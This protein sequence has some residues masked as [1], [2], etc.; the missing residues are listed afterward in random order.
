MKKKKM[1]RCQ[2]AIVLCLMAVVLLSGSVAAADAEPNQ[3]LLAILA[4][5][6]TDTGD[7]VYVSARPTINSAGETVYANYVLELPYGSAAT[8]V[9][10]P[11][12]EKIGGKIL[13]VLPA[14]VPSY[15]Y[16][17]YPSE[18]GLYHLPVADLLLTKLWNIPYLKILGNFVYIAYTLPVSDFAIT[19]ARGYAAQKQWINIGGVFDMEN[20]HFGN[21]TPITVYLSA[22]ENGDVADAIGETL[23]TTKAELLAAA[24]AEEDG[25]IEVTRYTKGV[26]L[27]AENLE[28]GAYYVNMKIGE[29]EDAVYTSQPYTVYATAK[30]YAKASMDQLIGYYITAPEITGDLIESFTLPTPIVAQLNKLRNA[31]YDFYSGV[32]YQG[33]SPFYGVFK[34]SATFSVYME[35]YYTG[36]A[37]YQDTG[38]DWE[39]WIFT[40]LG[41]EY[42]YE[43]SNGQSQFLDFSG[44]GEVL[45][46][47]SFLSSVADISTWLASDDDMT[48]L[49]VYA[50]SLTTFGV[51]SDYDLTQYFISSSSPYNKEA[52]RRVA[53]IMSMGADPRNPFPGESCNANHVAALLY[54]YYDQNTVT[55]DENG[56]ADYSEA[57]L[58]LTEDGK[59]PG[60]QNDPLNISYCMLALEMAN[61]S[62]EEGYTTELRQAFLKSILSQIE[63]ILA[64]FLAGEEIGDESDL[65]PGGGYTEAFAVDTCAMMSLPLCYAADDP[66]YGERI[67][68]IFAI[69]PTAFGAIVDA[70]GGETFYGTNPDS[71]AMAINALVSAG[72][73]AADLEDEKFQGSYQTLLSSLVNCQLDDGSISYGSDSGNG[74]RMATYQTMGAL[75]DLYNGESCFTVQ[76]DNYL[77]NYPQYTDE[78]HFFAALM[79]GLPEDAGDLLWSDVV[80]VT[81][82][83]SAY[84]ELLD[85]LDQGRK[86]NLAAYFSSRLE[87]LADLE[88]GSGTAVGAGMAS[89]PVKGQVLI[90][91][92]PLIAAMRAAYDIL[93]AAQKSVANGEDNQNLDRLR[94][95]EL[96]LLQWTAKGVSDFILSLP[97]AADV[98]ELDRADIE[99][100][101]AAYE[102]L[103][104]D[105]KALVSGETLKVLRDAE[106]ALVKLAAKN[107]SA[108][109]DNLPE[110]KDVRITDQSAIAAVRAAY[111]ALAEEQKALI[112]NYGKLLQVE[113]VLEELLAIVDPGS[114]T[115]DDMKDLRDKEDQWY[116]SSIAWCIENGIFEGDSQGYFHPDADITRAEFAQMI[117]NYYQD[118]AEVMLDGE[119]KSFPDVKTGVWY[120][121]A[122]NTC[123]KAGIIMGD[124]QGKFNPLDPITRQDVALVMMRIIKGQE[125]I[126]AIVLSER[127]ATLKEQGYVF[128]D[129]NETSPY[130]QQAI[131]AAAGVIFFGDGGKLNPRQNITRAQTAQVMYNYL[132]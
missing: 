51:E 17:I 50:Q 99:A 40:A 130:A 120:Y 100:A 108:N 24:G 87:I 71:V 80:N 66:V 72:Y 91:D 105:E 86:T 82:A 65:D 59:L 5:A 8:E 121:E 101:R 47:N 96:A 46:G 90:S 69:M 16:F 73:S 83:R 7:E 114:L 33:A 13:C 102:S 49:D 21:D 53:G 70:L 29:G 113:A 48:W 6:A 76:R 14:D 23:V 62:P 41:D 131:A 64:D 39:A 77:Y 4:S 84:E 20:I 52:F 132:K 15:D 36:L 9:T 125:A 28:A 81:A 98:T 79:D 43:N 11:D 126:D 54:T 97:S 38:T 42:L 32:K 1:W 106:R 78:G 119:G 25:I 115:I 122:V 123:A 129:F 26:G 94:D 55:W 58:R 35:P 37:N 19:P 10:L 3:D 112:T 63:T 34:P 93:P 103:S 88:N 27:L 74:N 44:D 110:S 56:V 128:A 117:Y 111:D 118:D 45:S 30:E 18:D 124:D 2:M 109:I 60:W 75:V 92:Q 57:K 31:G 61:A 127:L 85:S 107:V 89:L 104:E 68:E 67:K 95:A 22:Q 116:Y 12:S